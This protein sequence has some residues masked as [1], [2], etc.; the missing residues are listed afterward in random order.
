MEILDRT[1]RG[2]RQRR[3]FLSLGVEAERE[4]A[5]FTRRLSTG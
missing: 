5:R 2:Y 4:Y 1:S 3:C